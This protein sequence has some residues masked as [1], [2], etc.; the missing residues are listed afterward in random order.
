MEEARVLAPR[1]GAKVKPTGLDPKFASLPS[2]LTENPYKSL[3]VDPD[4]G[5]TPVNFRFGA[6]R[7]PGSTRA[8]SH[9]RCALH[10]LTAYPLA[11]YREVTKRCGASTPEPTMPLKC[12]T[13]PQ[14]ARPAARLPHLVP[15][16][17]QHVRA[18]RQL[19]PQPV[20]AVH[21]RAPRPRPGQRP[22]AGAQPRARLQILMRVSA[23]THTAAADSAALLSLSM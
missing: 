21:L 12:E 22:P 6:A 2:S 4:S 13:E 19:R 15:G 16:D 7:A 10:P 14:P 23:T 17:G 1:A 20:V 3:G 11:S 18:R 9:R 5:S 8:R